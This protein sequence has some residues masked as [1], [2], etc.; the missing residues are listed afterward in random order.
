MPPLSTQQKQAL[1]AFRRTVGFRGES[2]TLGGKPF[3]GIVEEMTT[4]EVNVSGG[5]ADAGGFR[6]MVD[7]TLLNQ[8]APAQFT[9]ISAQGMDL[10]VMSCLTRN[11]IIFEISAVD[12][13]AQD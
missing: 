9:P 11:G 10:S 13:V 6:V 5:K 8:E 2:F 1:N 3:R 12:P 4:D 7:F